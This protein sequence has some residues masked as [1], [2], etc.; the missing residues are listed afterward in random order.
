[1]NE[2][3]SINNSSLTLFSEG[4]TQINSQR[5]CTERNRQKKPFCLIRS[6]QCEK[7]K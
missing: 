6:E 4:D 1:M 5:N 3:L 7:E 2:I